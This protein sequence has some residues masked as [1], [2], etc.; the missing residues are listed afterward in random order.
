MSG[1]LGWVLAANLV[2]WSGLF[3]YLFR[4]DRRL[5]RAEKDEP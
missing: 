5:T 1:G 3:A 2:I 4:L